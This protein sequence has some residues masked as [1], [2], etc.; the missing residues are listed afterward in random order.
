MRRYNYRYLLNP[1]LV[2]VFL[3]FLSCNNDQFRTLGPPWDPYG[4]PNPGD[5]QCEDISYAQDTTLTA[6]LDIL[7][8]VDTSGSM[9]NELEVLSEQFNSFFTTLI[10]DH[11]NLDYQIAVMLAHAGANE[12]YS[13]VLWQPPASVCENELVLFGNADRSYD[14]AGLQCK[15]QNTVRADSVE[16]QGEAGLSTLLRALR[17]NFNVIRSPPN[18]SDRGF[19]RAD[20]GLAVI[21]VADE[22]DICSVPEGWNDLY[23]DYE[24]SEWRNAGHCTGHTPQAVYNGLRAAMGNQP[25]TIGTVVN[26]DIEIGNPPR[27]NPHYSWGYLGGTF[28]NPGGSPVE[29]LGILDLAGTNGI[30]TQITTNRLDTIADLQAIG[31]KASQSLSKRLTFVIPAKATSVKLVTVDGTSVS[32]QYIDT[33][34]EIHLAFDDAGNDGDPIKIN[35]CFPK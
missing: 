28:S 9:N 6:L 1:I 34:Q 27:Y 20:A 11:P 18:P 13:G 31:T 32:F 22:N 2:T 4:G 7:L 5:E 29:F 26:V 23:F 14:S 21:F 15:L 3:F 12:P 35:Y 8:I 25:L 24:E 33:T 10:A 17:D 19:F 16:D 30:A